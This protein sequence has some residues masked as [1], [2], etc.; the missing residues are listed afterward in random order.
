MTSLCDGAR[1][2]QAAL[3]RLIA[4]QTGRA[5]ELVATESLVLRVGRRDRRLTLLTLSSTYTVFRQ[6]PSWFRVLYLM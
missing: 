5:Q 4:E 3:L 2:L 6:T 1:G